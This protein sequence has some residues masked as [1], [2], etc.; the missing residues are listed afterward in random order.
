MMCKNFSFK[1]TYLTFNH[2]CYRCPSQ[3][4]PASISVSTITYIPQIELY[5]TSK[6]GSKFNGQTIFSECAD[7]IAT[8]IRHN[9]PLPYEQNMQHHQV[10]K[11]VKGATRQTSSTLPTHLGRALENTYKSMLQSFVNFACKRNLR[12]VSKISTLNTA[13]TVFLKKA[14]PLFAFLIMFRF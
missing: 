5:S 14:T 1:H 13:T 11:A 8:V 6:T 7:N 12:V 4:T 9:I 10:H 3:Y 2:N